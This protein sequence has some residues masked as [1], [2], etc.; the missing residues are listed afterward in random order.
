[1]VVS[2]RL[3]AVTSAEVIQEIL[4][5]FTALRRVELGAAMAEN[6]LDLFAPVVPITHSIMLR[7]PGLVRRY[8]HLA[9]RDLIHLATCV[10]L[11]FAA[12]VTPDRGFDIVAELT[13]IDPTERSGLEP[14]LR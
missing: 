2:G 8:G 3:D 13:R 7:M 9:A 5:R 6:A 14:H 4:H 10:E 12:I 1:M 11:G